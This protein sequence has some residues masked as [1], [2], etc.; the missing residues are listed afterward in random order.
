MTATA[1]PAL[2]ARVLK[3]GS[4]TLGGHFIGQSIRLATNIVLARLLAPDA[5]GL[6]SVVYVLMV[7]L[8]L[9]SDLGINRSVVQ[10][11]RG[12]EPALL[13]TAWTIQVIRGCGLAV[14]SLVIAGGFA[15]ANQ[16]GIVRAATVYAD[17][18]L[19]WVVGTFALVALLAGL[20]SIRIG[21]AKR[22]MQLKLLTS[23]DL[24]SQVAAG[25]VM[26]VA[27]LAF[28][29]I[30]ALVI[31]AVVAGG[32]RCGLGHLLLPG[33]QERLRLEPAAAKELLG[34]GKWV[35]L[36]SILG[37]AATN[38]DR[39]LLG[40]LIATSEFGLYAVA[41]LLVNVLQVVAA[42]LCINVAYPAFAEVHRERPQDLS[43]TISKFQWAYD[44]IVTLLAALLVTAGPAV[45]GLLYDARYQGAGWIM[46]VLAV[47]AIGL[48]YQVVEQCYQAVGRPEIA[49]LSNLVR[50]VG[51]GVGIVVGHRLF[52]FQG[53]VA[54]IALSQYWTWPVA[55]WFKHR[56]QALS[57]RA[58]AL[59]VP[60]ILV[61][62]L[63]GFGVAQ[64]IAVLQAHHLFS[65]LHHHAQQ[66]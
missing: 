31:G 14:L 34:H 52:G 51:L 8:Q 18:R 26:I 22:Q 13:D 19:P 38:G 36:S 48:R 30:W 15:L 58:E 46:S 25:V 11:P 28:H 55:L 32:L 23:I 24:S 7:G 20:E 44:G 65:G 47:G 62:A 60:A 4:W 40:G 33:H 12:H 66:H 2:R 49:T 50:L 57:L 37:F 3:A 43:R 17:P 6:M 29:S 53:A 10:S 27:A 16:L 1:K 5:F 59:L 56:H 35:F 39:L 21:L 54:G 41:F 45:I 63:L 64:G 9:F 42:T 61:G